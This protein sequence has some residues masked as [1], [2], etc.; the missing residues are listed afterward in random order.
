MT[1]LTIDV[2][3]DAPERIR[4]AVATFP[5]SFRTA[6]P[7]IADVHVIGGDGGWT[8]RATSLIQEGSRA[9][10]VGDPVVEDAR[11][12]HAV[13]A[14]AGASVLLAPAG[15]EDPALASL[16]ARLGG[17][18]GGLLECRLIASRSSSRS[19]TTMA[20]LNVLRSADSP[21]RELHATSGNEHGLHATGRL[22]SGR[23]VVLAID[24]S[25]A[26]RP[27]ARLR[28]IASVGVIQA[29]IPLSERSRPA[30]LREN[31]ALGEW[32]A[33]PAYLSSSRAVLARLHATVTGSP[34]RS[35]L[36]V[37]ERLIPVARELSWP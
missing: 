9:V 22:E 5:R 32:H 25:D 13:T 23:D 15:A 28:V 18:N 21:L 29:D 4:T 19:A 1:V 10:L 30:L 35:D 6:G 12:L 31:S 8:A 16:G 17:S 33:E 34:E 37:L 14:E 3:E 24:I 20:M 27:I 2:A 26:V 11:E 7:A 36:E